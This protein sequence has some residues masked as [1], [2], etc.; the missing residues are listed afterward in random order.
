ML[1]SLI[2]YSKNFL[3]RCF[4]VTLS[5]L[6]CNASYMVPCLLV[7]TRVTWPKSSKWSATDWRSSSSL[8]KATIPQTTSGRWSTPPVSNLSVRYPMHSHL[9]CYQCR[10]V[11]VHVCSSS[12]I[13]QNLRIFTSRSSSIDERPWRFFLPYLMRL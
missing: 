9:L 3:H 7:G 2:E 4:W 5:F 1:I 6:S 8:L 12:S 11:C 10:H 13:S